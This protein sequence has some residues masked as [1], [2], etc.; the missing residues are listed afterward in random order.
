MV[1]GG[2]GVMGRM[3]LRALRKTGEKIRVFTL[4]NDPGVAH[5]TALVDDICYGDISCASDVEYICEGINT[6]YHL[7]AIIITNNDNAY[8]EINVCGTR[9]IVDDAKQC[10]VQHFVYVSSA[11]VIYPRPTPY[12]LSKQMAERLVSESGIPFTIVRPTLV[13]DKSKGGVEF[14]MYLS[15][16]KRFPVVP[17]IG[18]GEAL[19]RPVYVQD[20]VQGLSALFGN[21]NAYGK[22]YNFSGGEPISIYDFSLFCLKLLGMPKKPILRLPLWFCTS[23]AHLFEYFLKNPPLKWSIV[24]GISQ[25]A[26]LSPSSA[27]EDLNYK[28]AKIRETLPKC[29]PRE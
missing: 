7:A 16:L 29:F 24:A 3:L 27:E 14:D 23:L 20:I 17:F 10:G 18:K 8:N 6:V 9:N 12:S 5:V 21:Q 1:T 25:D 2:T 13:Y 4:P 22:V 15:Y 11:S 19:K 28:P 26:N